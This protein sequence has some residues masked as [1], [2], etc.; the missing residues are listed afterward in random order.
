MFSE[1]HKE[2]QGFIGSRIY[3]DYK[4]QAEEKRIQQRR[5]LMTESRTLT[6]EHERRTAAQTKAI[7]AADEKIAKISKSL[8]QAQQEQREAHA[9]CWNDSC[10]TEAR[11]SQI[12]KQLREIQPG[13]FHSFVNEIETEIQRLGNEIY[14]GQES[15]GFGSVSGRPILQYAGNFESIRARIE[16]MRTDMLFWIHEAF[17]ELSSERD[18]RDEFERR[19]KLWPEIRL[20]KVA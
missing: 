15:A 8:L 2:I 5:E 14:S 13:C 19:K 17:L 7:A 16:M 6:S 4:R 3:Q 18:A 1:T 9:V 10:R 20:V 11:T 12:E